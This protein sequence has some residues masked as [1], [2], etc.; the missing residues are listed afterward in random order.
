M[1]KAEQPQPQS[2]GTATTLQN[3]VMQQENMDNCNCGSGEK[4]MFQCIESGCPSF[5]KQKLFCP[6][7]LTPEKHP[8]FPIMIALKSKNVTDEWNKIRQDVKNLNQRI[9]E[10]MGTHGALV[11]L[12]DGYLT[13]DDQSLNFQLHRLKLLGTNIENFYEQHVAES[14]AKGVITKLQELN[15]SLN[16]FNERFNSLKFLNKIGPSLLWSQYSKILHFVSHQQVLEKLSQASFQ[17]FLKLK[18]Y[19]VQLSLKEVM[20]ETDGTPNNIEEFLENPDLS[21]GQFIASLQQQLKRVTSNEQV[22]ASDAVKVDGIRSDL[23]AIGVSLMFTGLLEK[24]NN[25]ESQI[26]HSQNAKIVELTEKNHQ[27]EERLSQL[28]DSRLEDMKA[29]LQIERQINQTRFE[30]LNGSATISHSLILNDEEKQ[31]KI[32]SFMEQGGTPLKY[33]RL[34]YRGSQDTFAANAFHLK[35]NNFTNTLVFVKTTDGK[36]VGGFTTQ[37]WNNTSG[38]KQDDK[39][40]LFNM[41]ANN[42]FKVKQGG[43]NAI[44]ASSSYGPTF[45][46]GYDLVIHD[47]CNTNTNYATAAAYEYN[48]SGNIFLTQA[49]VQ[50][51]VQEIEVYQV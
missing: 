48:G 6:L 42:I 21:I 47:N 30:F 5:S 14:S 23:D 43:A 39:A 38:Y 44:Y 31:I 22:S 1:E 49:Q 24:F 50:F 12:L 34:L 7:C 35:T 19:R 51:Q 41:Q 17:V 2:K 33:S 26:I 4:V 20:K 37:T 28:I 8:H 25:L 3:L 16:A 36:I 29:E 32:K 15:P 45:G 9:A 46:S 10:W 18:L 27:L 13:N 11:E 40:W